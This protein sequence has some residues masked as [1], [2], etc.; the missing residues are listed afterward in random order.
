MLGS[1]EDLISELRDMD[2]DNNYFN[3]DIHFKFS[4]NQSNLISDS[5]Y[6]EVCTKKPTSS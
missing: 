2:T 5:E 1:Q 4:T 6:N 3:N